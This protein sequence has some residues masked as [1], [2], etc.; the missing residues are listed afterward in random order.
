MI[1]QK[2]SKLKLPTL[3]GRHD[4]NKTIKSSSLSQYKEHKASIGRLH[5]YGEQRNVGCLKAELH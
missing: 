3:W 5:F 1:P 4:P 2:P